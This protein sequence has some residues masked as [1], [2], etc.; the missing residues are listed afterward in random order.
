MRFTRPGGHEGRKEHTMKK[1]KNL[2]LAYCI[3]VI[4]PIDPEFARYIS[5]YTEKQLNMKEVSA[6]VRDRRD[7][8]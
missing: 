8:G 1:Q 6:Y 4:R 7:N 2:S 3:R 5:Q